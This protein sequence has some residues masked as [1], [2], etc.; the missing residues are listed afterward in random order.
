MNEVFN[1][2]LYKMSFYFSGYLKFFQRITRDFEAAMAK[3]NFQPIN[4]SSLEGEKYQ[5]KNNLANFEDFYK[6]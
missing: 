6:N 5:E 4:T 2:S 1:S 3:V